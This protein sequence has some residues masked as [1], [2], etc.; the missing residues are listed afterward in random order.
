MTA[1]PPA[2]GRDDEPTGPPA[3]AGDELA[4][5]PSKPVPKS[6]IAVKDTREERGNE[7]APFGQGEVGT[8]TL[9]RLIAF[10][11][12]MAYFCWLAHK[13]N[14]SAHRPE[15]RVSSLRTRNPKFYWLCVLLDI[16]VIIVAVTILVVA[17]GAALYKTIWL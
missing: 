16:L 1:A 14:P 3:E 2:F 10:R 11:P 8:Q 6:Q 4:K 9:T 13:Q 12:F 7:P 5:P 15:T 17:A